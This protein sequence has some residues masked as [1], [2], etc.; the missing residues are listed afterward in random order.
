M[1]VLLVSTEDRASLN[2]RDRLTEEAE[3]EDIGMYQG[4]PVLQHGDLILMEKVGTHLYFERVD[5][6]IN[7]ALSDII[8]AEEMMDVLIF[9][10][11]H[12]S[13]MDIHSLT[14]HPPG[15][16]LQ[17]D[18]GGMPGRLP[19]SSPPIMSAALRTLYREKKKIGLSDQT[20]YEVTHH[21]PFLETPSF[22]IEIGSDGS[23]WDIPELGR[24]IARTLLSDE[25]MDPD[26]ALPVAIG[27]GGGHYAPRFTDRAMRKKFDF[28]H[29]IPDYI[30]QNAND[31]KPLIDLALGATPGVEAAFLHRTS[32]N[33]V[34]IDEASEILKERG[35]EIFQ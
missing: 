15:N 27:I 2:I 28:G 13:E 11:R 3:W 34:I 10:S 22:F 1:K 29:M 17:A 16:F 7:E 20:T 31:L 24:A 25:L 19:P 18:Y 26:R 30:L 23:R 6:E 8:E 32:R 33:R 5:R 12:R 9:L 14:V 4:R 21:G 35:I